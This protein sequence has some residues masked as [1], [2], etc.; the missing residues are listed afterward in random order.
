MVLV[1]TYAKLYIGF[2]QHIALYSNWCVF[3]SGNEFQ[4]QTSSF[5]LLFLNVYFTGLGMDLPKQMPDKKQSPRA[6]SYT[7]ILFEI[8]LATNMVLTCKNH[9]HTDCRFDDNSSH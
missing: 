3:M 1:M 8:Q 6:N 2:T 9:L 5:V 7:V 4:T